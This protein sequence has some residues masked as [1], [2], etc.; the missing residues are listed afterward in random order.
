MRFVSQIV[1]LWLLLPAESSAQLPPTLPLDTRFEASNLAGYLARFDSVG[2]VPA[3]WLARNWARFQPVRSD[4]V[5]YGSDAR[6][7]FLLFRVNNPTATPLRLVLN[8]QQFFFDTTQLF[9]YDSAGSLLTRQRSGWQV[10]VMERPLPLP[11]HNFRISVPPYQTRLVVLHTKV[12]ARQQVSNAIL[13][14][15]DEAHFLVRTAFELLINGV[16]FGC[17]L[18]VGCYGMA[19]FLYTRQRFYGYFSL[20]VATFSLYHLNV[21]GLFDY[22]LSAPTVM[23]DPMFGTV[24]VLAALAFQGGFYLR[25]LNVKQYAPRWL[26]VFAYVTVFGVSAVGLMTIFWPTIL[27]VKQAALCTIAV[28]VVAMIACLGVGAY[29]Q[30]PGTNWMIVALLPVLALTGYH[31]LAGWLLPSYLPLYITANVSPVFVFEVITLG[32]GLAFR[33]NVDR[34]RA[35]L[36]LADVER[37]T[38]RRVMQAQEDERQ[39]LAADLHDDLGGTLA[40]L[41]GE[42][43]RQVEEQNEAFAPALSLTE[44]AVKDLRLISH[45]LMPTAFAQKGLRQVLEEAVD[46]ANRSRSRIQVSLATY[47][48]ER[49]LP[50]DHEINTY[51]II[52]EWLTN[53]LKHAQAT[54]IVVQL[55]YYESFLYASVE[56]NGQGISAG[57]SP[58]ETEG[59]GLKNTQLRA[60][61]LRARISIDSGPNGTLMAV[62]VPYPRSSATTDSPITSSKPTTDARPS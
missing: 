34:K 15:H 47:G 2:A 7:H 1:L 43:S 38:T 57:V 44:R 29:R 18:L 19:L 61:Y 9:V 22:L 53:A 13:L 37:T 54:Q 51:R 52:R 31:L 26:T 11:I 17:L 14:L 21:N 20:Y 58:S 55:I 49:R 28:Y 62:E 23:A 4:M 59:I 39:Q 60:D 8:L 50:L 41:Q 12:N 46:L 30:Q 3:E 32:I 5:N 42:L 48:T 45:H 40:T 35:I 56:D 33:F 27:L 25:F 10:P 24:M 6:H 36:R 16:M